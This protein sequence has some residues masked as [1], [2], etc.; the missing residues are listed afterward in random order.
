VCLS[1]I[2]FYYFTPLSGGKGG[3]KE[4]EKKKKRE[5][6]RIRRR[7]AEW[8]GA[9]RID[10]SKTYFQQGT[11]PIEGIEKRKKGGEGGGGGDT[12]NGL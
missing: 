6:K 3:R 12:A 1:Y 10:G 8:L 7:K 11:I 9:A 4:G 5:K 2:A